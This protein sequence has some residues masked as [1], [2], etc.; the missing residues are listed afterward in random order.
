MYICLSTDIL[1]CPFVYVEI[2]CLD[3]HLY[4]GSLRVL[5]VC[6]YKC[7]CVSMCC[8]AFVSQGALPHIESSIGQELLEVVGWLREVQARDGDAESREN[9]RKLLTIM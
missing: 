1:R 9:A 8:V 6:T 3:V 7:V 2:L 4:I 5:Y